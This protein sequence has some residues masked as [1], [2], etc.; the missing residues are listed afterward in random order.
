MSRYLFLEV[1]KW[2]VG[3]VVYH[4][5][6]LALAAAQREGIDPEQLFRRI[7]NPEWKQCK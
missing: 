4:S 3:D 5:W 2:M 7:E 6:T 1:N